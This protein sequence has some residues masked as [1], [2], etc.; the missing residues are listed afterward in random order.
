[1]PSGASRPRTVSVGRA[2]ATNAGRQRRLGQ[3]VGRDQHVAADLLGGLEQPRRDV[4]RVADIGDLGADIA[5]LAGDDLAA[6]HGGAE[7]GHHAEPP[8]IL[9]AA[10]GDEVAQRRRDR[11]A[12]RRRAWRASAGQVRMASSPTYL[13]IS[14]PHSRAASAMSRKKSFK[15]LVEAHGAQPLGDARRVLHVDQQEGPQLSARPDVAA[16]QPACP[17]MRKPSRLPIVKTT[18]AST[19]MATEKVEAAAFEDLART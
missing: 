2:S 17:T 16:G 7:L 18:L 19:D 12:R 11:R 9:R 1:M 13:W 14:A 4:Q 10:G 6:M 8:A 15:Q 3:Q 5:D